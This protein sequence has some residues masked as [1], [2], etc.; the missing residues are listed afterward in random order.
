MS[1]VGAYRSVMLLPVHCVVCRTLGST[2]CELCAAQLVP[3]PEAPPLPPLDRAVA[4]F[5]YEG[6]GRT[7]V[8]RL[9]FDGHRD[10][11]GPMG[12]ML[13]AAI[14]APVD[15]VTWVPTSPARRRRRG[16]DQAELLA[17]STARS[18]GVPVRRTVRRQTGPAQTGLD[19][20][21]RMQA[22]FSPVGRPPQGFVA[23]VDDVRT[24][25]A[26]LTGVARALRSSGARS[27]VGATLAATSGTTSGSASYFAT[28][29]LQSG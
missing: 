16:Y 14:D 18:L 3:A 6:V 12:A 10:A 17:R 20:A 5:A 9:K 1:G 27:V 15:L 19:R 25:G 23:V 13:A 29:P 8:S 2:L 21:A 24:T 7:V 4:L 26:S 28:D 11:V 22:S